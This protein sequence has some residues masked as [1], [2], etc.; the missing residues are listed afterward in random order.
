METGRCTRK[1]VTISLK[2]ELVS[3]GRSYKGVLD[4]V[5]ES[6]ARWYQHAETKGS[7]SEYGVNTRI[8][9]AKTAITFSCETP[10]KLKFQLSSGEKITLNCKIKWSHKNQPHD[11]TNSLGMDPPSEYT[12]MGMEIVCPSP[13]YKE[14]FK[15][16][17]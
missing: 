17:R 12:E 9:P 16:L 1:R 6:G 7:L 15:N 2:A 4:N 8:T 10:V 5:S 11:L 14:F 13:I 3:N